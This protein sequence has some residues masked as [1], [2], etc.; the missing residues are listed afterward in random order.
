MKIVMKEKYYCIRTKISLF[1]Q[2][3]CLWWL[4]Y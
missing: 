2:Y 1:S 4:H 3:L